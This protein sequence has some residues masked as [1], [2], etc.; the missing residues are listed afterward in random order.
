MSSPTTMADTALQQIA[1]ASG[2]AY[3]YRRLGPT[4]GVPLVFL[5]HFRGDIDSWDPAFIDP[6]AAERDVILVDNK[7]AGG[8]GGTAPA[9]AEEMTAVVVEFVEALGFNRIDVFGYSIGGFVAQELALGHPTHIRRVILASTGP[10]GAPGMERWSP[11]VVER[12]VV[13][14]VPTLEN[15]LDVF[16]SPSDASRAAGK[17]SLGRIYARRQGRDSGVPLTTR[18]VQYNNVVL[19]WGRPDWAAVQRLVELQ[20]PTLILQGDNDVMIP[21]RASHLLAGLIPNAQIQIYP[22]ASHGAIFQYAQD[23]SRR[24]LEFTNGN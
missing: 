4:G 5:Q 11:Y 22:D 20:Q 16:Y 3:T 7:G 17:A 21:T 2:Q 23:A 12:L 19:D 9:T 1:A 13:T 8:T 18:D 15:V 14:D 24:V 10:K 6:I